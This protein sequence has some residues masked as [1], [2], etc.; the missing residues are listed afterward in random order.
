MASFLLHYYS[1]IIHIFLRKIKLFDLLY[2]RSKGTSWL[3]RRWRSIWDFDL[4]VWNLNRV[5]NQRLWRKHSLPFSWIIKLR[6][7]ILIWCK[8]YHF[9]HHLIIFLVFTNHSS[10]LKRHRILFH[11]DTLINTNRVLHFYLR[12]R[13]NFVL[14]SFLILNLNISTA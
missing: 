3:Y 14:F 7:S 6:V 8:I 13:F 1:D 5:H 2:F 12:R 9:S 4:L 10:L 11:F